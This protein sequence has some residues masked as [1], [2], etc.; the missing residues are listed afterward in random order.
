MQG[1]VEGNIRQGRP[2]IN[3]MYNIIE[4]TKSDILDNTLD[5]DKWKKI[6]V[7]VAIQIPYDQPVTGLTLT[8]DYY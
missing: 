2:R 6:C 4:W 8:V 3:W 5:R 1:F 7:I